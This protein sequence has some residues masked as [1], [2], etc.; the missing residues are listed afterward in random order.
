MDV[1]DKVK[2]LFVE[3]ANKLAEEADG[4]I[5]IEVVATTP[6]TVVVKRFVEVE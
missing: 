4:L 1:V 2:L 6:F 5:I 3:E